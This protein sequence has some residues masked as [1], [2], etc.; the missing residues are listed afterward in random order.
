MDFGSWEVLVR[1][2]YHICMRVGWVGR[3]WWAEYKAGVK[4]LSWRS[5]RYLNRARSYEGEGAGWR[6]TWELK[7]PGQRQDS[8]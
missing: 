4:S 8:R 2:K 6:S 3:Q 1:C 5:S 7:G